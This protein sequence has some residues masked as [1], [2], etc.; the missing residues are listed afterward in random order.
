M[1]I[2]SLLLCGLLGFAVALAGFTVR[3]QSSNSPPSP[4]EGTQDTPGTTHLDTWPRTFALDDAR[5]R[6][7]QPQ[8]EKWEG[9]RLDFRA[10][11]EA[12][13]SGGTHDIFGVVSGTARTEVNRAARLVTLED[14]RLTRSNFPTLPDNGRAYREALEQQ[15][16]GA[17]RTIALDR[18]QASLAAS[19]TAHSG[20]VEVRNAPPRIIVSYSPAILIPISGTPVIKEVPDSRFERVINTRAL[21]MRTHLDDTWFLHVYDGWL[22]ASHIMGPWSRAAHTPLRMDDVADRLAKH[23][24][25]DLLDGGDS[26]QRPSLANGV[27]KVYV[28]EITAELIVFKGQPN[29]VPVSN[30]KL[31]WAENTTADV[32]VDT[33]NNDYYALVSGRWFRGPDLEQ[34][35]WQYVASNRLPSDFRHIPANS[36][37]GAVLASVAG[38]PQAKEALIAN[39]I[40]QTATVKRVDGPSFKPVI[41]GSPQWRAIEGTPLKSVFNAEMPLIK[42]PDGTLYALSAGVWFTASQISGPW[43]V[44][45]SVPKVIYSIPPSSALYYVTFVHVYGFTPEVVYVG[46]TPGYLGTVVEPDG[47]VVYGTGYKYEPWVGDV[48]YAAPDTY[49]VQA[50]PVYNPAAD[51]A[52]GMALGLTTAAMVDSWGGDVYYHPYYYGYPCCGSTSANVYRHWGNTVTSGTNTWYT[53]SSGEIGEK[54]SGSYTNYRT[55]ST[56]TYSANR[57]ANP[58]KGTAGRSYQRSVDTG[59]GG[60]GNVSRSESYNAKTGETQYSADMSGTTKGGSTISRDSTAQWG[61][62][63]GSASHETTV[64]NAKTGETHTYSSGFDGND[65]YAS[66][67]GEN[68]RNDGSGWQKQTSSGWQSVS[69]K[70]SNWADRER[71]ARS[72]GQARLDGLGRGG[73]DGGGLLSHLGGGGLLNRLGGGLR[74]GGGFASR[75][76]G[77][78]FGGRFGGFRGRR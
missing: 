45:T 29:F 5:L 40:P 52:F 67:N 51:M 43:K 44:A 25:A 22:S 28:S 9:N 37:A 73:S 57:Y 75:F 66:A 62:Q 7:F 19:G 48:Y 3:A 16:R 13:K 56:G 64:T 77:G 31:L 14:L 41:D 30:T 17:K 53:K 6:V 15:W 49:G 4:S 27:P 34:G 26:Q 47:V 55:G 58:Y 76:G 50:Q 42:V 46:Y 35:P 59:R 69:A 18:L 70:N 60:A 21:I 78:G 1:R 74:S 24:E 38:T 20:G 65:R 11:V 54:A 8:V 68:F 10:A 63:G 36:K 71:Q 12:K 23:G 32:F 33:S 72:Q 2:R 39:T 61:A